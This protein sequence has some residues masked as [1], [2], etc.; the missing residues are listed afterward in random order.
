MISKEQEEILKI[1]EKLPPEKRAKLTSAL[2]YEELTIEEI[3]QEIKKEKKEK[4]LSIEEVA[5]QDQAC[6]TDDP[7]FTTYMETRTQYGLF[8]QTEIIGFEK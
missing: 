2:L 7:T 8:R 6:Q 1:L 4:N 3:E 5:H